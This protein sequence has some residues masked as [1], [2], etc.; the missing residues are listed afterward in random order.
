MKPPL[1]RVLIVDDEPRSRVLVR[2]A[3]DRCGFQCDL[4]SD[5]AEARQR[6]DNSLYDVVVTELVLP[7]G[8]GAELIADLCRQ[9]SPPT[10][11]VHM[12][13]HE[14]EVYRG[15]KNEGVDA[16]F[17]KPADSETMARKIQSLVEHQS[18]TRT[19]SNRWKQIRRETVQSRPKSPLAY[20]IHGDQWLQGSM[21]RIEIFRFTIVLLA[22][23]VF[24][25]GWG[26]LLAPNIAGVC[27]MFGLCGLAFYFAL[28]LVAYYRI[29]HRARLF[30]CSAE[31]RLANQSEVRREFADA[32][33]LSDRLA[34]AVSHSRL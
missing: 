29:Q 33:D 22:C 34:R 7:Q 21:M 25:L 5:E 8:N 9:E 17:Y 3:L 26:S 14:P 32:T 23:I 12:S 1:G 6:I 11:V 28:E 16:V 13:I 15:L 18:W 19:V 31:R 24:S 20:F 30:R 27:R 2:N 4:V 10:V